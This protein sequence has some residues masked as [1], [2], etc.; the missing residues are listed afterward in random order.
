MV[1]PQAF[2]WT[3]NDWRGVTRDNQIIYEMH[4][5]TFS[6]EGTW[7]GAQRELAE[8]AAAGITIIEAM[9]VA[10]F[11]GRFGWGYDGVDLFAPTWL[12]GQ[13]DDMRAFVNE[14]H[15]QGIGVILDVVYNHLGRR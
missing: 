4:V 5:G 15:A 11:P 12:Y 2:A 8:L 6:K 9:P 7:Q 14:A 13:P 3:D 1:D 10:D